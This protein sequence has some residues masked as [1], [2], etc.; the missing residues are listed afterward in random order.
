VASATYY[1]QLNGYEHLKQLDM[2]YCLLFRP[3][4]DDI[5]AVLDSDLKTIVHIPNVTRGR[6]RSEA[7]P[8]RSARSWTRSAL[9]K[10]RGG[11]WL[12]PCE[13]PTTGCCGLPIWLTTAL[14]ARQGAGC[15]EGPRPEEQPDH[16]DII[17]A[18]GMAKEGFD[19]IWCEHALTVGYAPA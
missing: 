11:H 16:V 1:E 6:A 19:W 10:A 17:I 15:A 13:A 7:R 2:G 5:A 14:N 4:V 9:G 8:P 3:Y 12:R 18:L